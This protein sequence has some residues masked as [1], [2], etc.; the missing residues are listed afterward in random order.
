MAKTNEYGTSSTDGA[1]CRTRV[2][3]SFSTGVAQTEVSARENGRVP[4]LTHTNNAL[5]GKIKTA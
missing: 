4:D 5:P 3:K 1:F 2:S